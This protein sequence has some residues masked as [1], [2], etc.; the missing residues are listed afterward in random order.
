MTYLNWGDVPTWIGTGSF[1][2]AA[3]AYQLSVG[4]WFALFAGA[5][6]RLTEQT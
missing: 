4:N 1:F 2:I 3:T 5:D 6:R